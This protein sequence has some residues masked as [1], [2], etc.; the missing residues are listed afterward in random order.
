MCLPMVEVRASTGR[1]SRIF[2]SYPGLTRQ[3]RL[4]NLQTLLILIIEGLQLIVER[5]GGSKDE[6]VQYAYSEDGCSTQNDSFAF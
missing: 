5:S 6:I 1:V 2:S 3:Q 4:P